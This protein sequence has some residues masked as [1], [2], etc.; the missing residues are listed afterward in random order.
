[1]TA[2][3]NTTIEFDDDG[4]QLAFKV[5]SQIC[6]AGAQGHLLTGFF[7]EFLIHHFANA[8]TSTEM[9][10]LRRLVWDPEAGETKI[11]IEAITRELPE[12]TEKRPAILIRR[13]SVASV[14][15]G[16]GSFA[17]Y[18]EDFQENYTE[19]EVGSHTLFVINGGKDGMACEYLAAEVKRVLRHYS[20]V[21]VQTLGLMDFQVQQLGAV[22]RI[23]EYK[24]HYTV[25]ITV[26]WA[27]ADSW[28][29]VQEAPVL[30]R[31]VFNA[32]FNPTIHD[33]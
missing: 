18:G 6:A 7:R 19:L 3:S 4:V 27:L 29:L 11:K 10:V 2:N 8:P 15:R 23:K 12:L 16:I 25:P 5:V 21:I 31:V 24:E 13:N 33:E 32:V 28:K 30:R 26:G 22:S 17:G 20:H 14:R 9:E 1:M